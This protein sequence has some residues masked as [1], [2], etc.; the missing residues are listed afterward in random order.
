MVIANDKNPEKPPCKK[1]G[2]SGPFVPKVLTGQKDPRENLKVL[3]K[4]CK[5]DLTY[6]THQWQDDN[7]KRYVCCD[8]TASTKSI[9]DMTGGNR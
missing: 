5:R 4:V 3:C 8:C 1:C 7:S 2:H 6:D 9:R